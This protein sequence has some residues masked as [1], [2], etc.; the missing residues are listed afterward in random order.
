MGGTGHRLVQAAFLTS[1]FK[2]EC[3]HRCCCLVQH[4]PSVISLALTYAA[5]AHPYIHCE[6][7]HGAKAAFP[8]SGTS[9]RAYLQTQSWPQLDLPGAM[10]ITSTGAQTCICNTGSCLWH[11]GDGYLQQDKAVFPDN[12]IFAST[13]N[14]FTDALVMQV[15]VPVT[16]LLS[17]KRSI[18]QVPSLPLAG[19]GYIQ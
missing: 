11:A 16:A 17:L 1:A 15:D 7:I 12:Y 10:N 2:T 18:K 8:N 14:I 13:L 19:H 5:V 4:L 6:H 3:V 9:S